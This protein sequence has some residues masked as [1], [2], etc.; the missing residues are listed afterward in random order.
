[1]KTQALLPV[2]VLGA[3]LVAVP[4]V[5]AGDRHSSSRHGEYHS[6]HHGDRYRSAPPRYRHD[7]HRHYRPAPRYYSPPPRHRYYEPRYRH[8]GPTYY[9]APRPRVYYPPVYPVPVYPYRAYAPLPPPYRAG[10]HGGV[11]LGLPG[12]GL[13]LYF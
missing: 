2:L 3:V 9:Y 4:V 11:H 6:D 10:V 13:S 8:Y 1:M 5:G 7:S 12:L